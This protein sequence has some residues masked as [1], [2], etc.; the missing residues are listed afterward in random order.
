MK[1]TYPKI[2]ASHF[3]WLLGIFL[4]Y[5]SLILT[6]IVACIFK[7]DSL[8]LGAVILS[9]F[10]LLASLVIDKNILKKLFI[11]PNF[12]DIKMLVIGIFFSFLFVFLASFAAQ[13][14]KIKG[15]VNPI[16]DILPNLKIFDLI[17]SSA[18][19]FIGEEILFVLPFLYVVNKMEKIPMGL[20]VFLA[21][22]ISSLLFG[23]LHI[24]TYN[25][26]IGQSLIIIGLVRTGITI[27][28]LL[29]KNLSISYLTHGIYD[30]T[31]IY[32]A[33]K[34]NLLGFLMAL[35]I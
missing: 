26:N 20:R 29:T 30:W 9:A 24:P 3:R 6:Y 22:I 23:A 33:V 28:Y 8:I 11:F 10:T 14:L 13:I 18:I 31:L 4:A 2:E 27:S 34:F 1:R 21:V 7:I 35:V 5:F 32:I 17:L 16:F 19:Q 12:R 25:F 15:D